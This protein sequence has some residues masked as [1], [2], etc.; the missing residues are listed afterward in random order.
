MN[1]EIGA[2][3]KVEKAKQNI[4]ILGSLNQVPVSEKFNEML[5]KKIRDGSS[6][7]IYASIYKSGYILGFKPINSLIFAG[8]LIT[9]I[10]LGNEMYNETFSSS[11]KNPGFVS[12]N[13]SIKINEIDSTLNQN[14]SI[15]VKKNN[16]SNKI[17]LVNDK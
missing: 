3:D 7:S 9:F 15:K 11:T 8:L 1:N 12:K 4:I 10:F 16:Y 13:R 14:D 6:K 2:K 5:M 17:R